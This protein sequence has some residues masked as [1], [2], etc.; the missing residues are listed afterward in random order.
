MVRSRLWRGWWLGAA[1]AWGMALFWLG[2]EVA[3]SRSRARPVPPEILR[4][5]YVG[6]CDMKYYA[7]YNCCINATWYSC[8]SVLRCPS[9]DCPKQGTKTTGNCGPQNQNGGQSCAVVASSFSDCQAASYII[10]TD[11]CEFTGR[12]VPCPD[13]PNLKW[14][15]INY[16]S[17]QDNE[18]TITVCTCAPGVTLCDGSLQPSS[19]CP[20][21]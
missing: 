16:T 4:T 2:G 21:R 10:T 19:P 15:E 14:C 12:L 6:Q 11:V 18:Q 17:P 1:A 9:M 20:T 13:N 3:R 8:K 7:K 5:T